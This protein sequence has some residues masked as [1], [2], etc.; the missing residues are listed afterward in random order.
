MKESKVKP[1]V[2]KGKWFEVAFI[3]YHGRPIKIEDIFLL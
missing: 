3:L 1:T 2:V